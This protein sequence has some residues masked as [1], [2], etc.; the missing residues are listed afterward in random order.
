MGIV[1]DILDDIVLTVC[2]ATDVELDEFFSAQRS[3][4]IVIARQIFA[5]KTWENYNGFITLK[6]I[7]AYM[8]RD[9]ASVIH[10]RDTSKE[11]Y[12]F[13]SGYRKLLD[14]VEITKVDLYHGKRR[15][16]KKI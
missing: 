16:E 11:D 2:E 5:H 6:E 1:I 12:Q 4:R 15:V 3:R 8:G 13:S 7:G 9:H 14:S 10:N